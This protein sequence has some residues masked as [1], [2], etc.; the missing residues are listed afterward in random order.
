MTF[1]LIIF[2]NAAVLTLLF[3][4]FLALARLWSPLRAVCVGV[5]RFFIQ[6]CGFNFS[7]QRAA[8]GRRQ[9]FTPE[10]AYMC[11]AATWARPC[12]AGQEWTPLIRHLASPETSSWVIPRPSCNVVIQAISKTAL[13]I[14]GVTIHT[15][16]SCKAIPKRSS[17]VVTETWG[18]SP[19]CGVCRKGRKGT[20]LLCS[21]SVRYKFACRGG[22]CA[23]LLRNEK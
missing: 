5:K 2:T 12:Q 23:S 18:D 13:L 14:H 9:P 7:L 21:V 15:V 20:L 10:W 8:Q 19:L 11:F 17:R 16:W 4:H 22:Y 1:C 3:Q 6:S